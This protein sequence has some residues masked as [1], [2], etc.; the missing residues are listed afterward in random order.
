[1][2]AAWER[3]KEREST[4]LIWITESFQLFHMWPANQIIARIIQPVVAVERYSLLSKLFIG[5]NFNTRI[6]I[7]EL[8]GCL[9]GGM[10]IPSNKESV[11]IVFTAFCV[12]FVFW[13]HWCKRKNGN[14]S[15]TPS[16][17]CLVGCCAHVKNENCKFDLLNDHVGS[18][19]KTWAE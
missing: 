11:C 13:W 19:V 10:R 4:S 8:A 18:L 6:M 17:H 3:E 16:G 7:L 12:L 2:C 5:A 1:M 14:E 9:N 15:R